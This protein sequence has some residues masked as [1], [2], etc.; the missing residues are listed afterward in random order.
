MS[1]EAIRDCVSRIGYTLKALTWI[2]HALTSELERI[3]LTVCAKA[4]QAPGIP[5][6]QSVYAYDRG[7]ELIL[8]QMCSR[9]DMDITG[10]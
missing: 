9:P 1:H 10:S 5:V 4:V 7:R 2:P 8:S 3:R 6:Q